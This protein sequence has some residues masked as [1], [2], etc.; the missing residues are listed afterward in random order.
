MKNPHTHAIPHGTAAAQ[1]RSLPA[2]PARARSLSP[3]R[4]APAA[5]PA[6]FAGIR[7]QG[8]PA[9]Q[10]SAWLELRRVLEAAFCADSAAAVSPIPLICFEGLPGAGKSTQ[11]AAVHD[12]CELK[13]GRGEIID[14]PSDSPIGLFL[15]SLY[16]DRAAWQRIQSANPWLNPILLAADL[17]LAVRAAAERGARYALVDRGIIS[18]VFYNIS[19]YAA[20]E[21]AAWAAMEP[22]LAAFYRPAVTLFLDLPAEVAHRRVV[23]RRRGALRTMD[24]PEQMRADRAKLLRCQA[25]LPQVPFCRINAALPPRQVTR[26]IMDRLPDFLL[27]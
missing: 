12:A 2:L 19:A 22:H 24:M 15:K 9:Q 6:P 8:S 20:D 11:I 17:R 23:A 4:T 26:A 14:P 21:D 25:R 10:E 3:E 1:S 5:Q 27:A 13:Y 7:L 18:T 16:A